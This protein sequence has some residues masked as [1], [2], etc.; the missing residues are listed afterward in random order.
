MDMASLNTRVGWAATANSSIGWFRDNSK[1]AYRT[2]GLENMA[3]YYWYQ[4]NLSGNGWTTWNCNGVIHVGYGGVGGNNCHYG[5]R[6]IAAPQ[7][8]QDGAV[9]A[10]CNCNCV[11]ACA[12]CRYYSSFGSQ[13]YALTAN[14]NCDGNFQCAQCDLSGNCDSRNWMQPNCNCVQ[15]NCACNCYGHGQCIDLDCACACEGS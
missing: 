6:T 7:C 10:N 2:Y 12:N 9:M 11:N 13:P 3:G 5:H 1:P 4:S 8:C 15:C 14:N